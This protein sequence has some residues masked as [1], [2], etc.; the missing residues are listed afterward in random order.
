MGCSP[1]GTTFPGLISWEVYSRKTLLCIYLSRRWRTFHRFIFFEK[2]HH[3]KIVRWENFL[4]RLLAKW[5]R[6]RMVPRVAIMPSSMLQ[7]FPSAFLPSLQLT[8]LLVYPPLSWL[9]RDEK[10][11]EST[12]NTIPK[13]T[14]LA[15]FSRLK[16]LEE[17]KKKSFFPSSVSCFVPEKIQKNTFFH[18]FVKFRTQ[19]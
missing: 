13:H 15:F 18:P 2:K 12:E 17:E 7:S 11:L 16:P 10:I 14:Q 1:S 5:K 9:R 3:R 19:A 8:C 4:F 6:K